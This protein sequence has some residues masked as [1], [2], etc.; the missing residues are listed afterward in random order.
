MSSFKNIENKHDI[1]RG[2]DCMKKFCEYLREHITLINFKK[3]KLLTK[4]HQELY[5]NV[6]ICYI[7]NENLK[8]NI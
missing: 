4:Q 6:K 8:L 7:C 5:E 3:I 1:Y 2:K